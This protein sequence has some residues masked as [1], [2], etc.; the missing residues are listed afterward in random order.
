MKVCLLMQ[1]LDYSSPFVFNYLK[2]RASCKCIKPRLK[3]GTIKTINLLM[4]LSGSTYLVGL[5]V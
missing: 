2:I 5:S 1:I 3:I 4:P